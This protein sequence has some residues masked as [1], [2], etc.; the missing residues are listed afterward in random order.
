MIATLAIM[1]F[2]AATPANDTLDAAVT[3]FDNA[4]VKTRGD[5]DAFRQTASERGWVAT[6]SP[7]RGGRDW[8]ENFRAAGFAAS[9]NH[10]PETVRGSRTIPEQL[11]CSITIADVPA[12]WRSRL[13]TAEVG[14]AQ[15]GPGQ[16]PG[17]SYQ[18]PPGF[19]VVVWDRGDDR[20]HATK[21]SD[22]AFL[23]LS[24]N[25]DRTLGR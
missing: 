6:S 1:S 8:A 17:A 16:A 19:E 13:E 24:I 3:A 11:S 10:T 9:L 21:G 14:S 12:D 18:M 2:L 4:C 5:R 22:G 23:E 20:I 7:L 25:Y 15:L